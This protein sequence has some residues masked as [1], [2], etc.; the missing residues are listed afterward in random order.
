[1]PRAIG[2]GLL[3]VVLATGCVAGGDT[4]KAKTDGKISEKLLTI[5][6]SGDPLAAAESRGVQTAHDGVLV[7]VQTE[8]LR[9]EDRSRFELDGVRVHHF[10]A[11]YERVSASVRD[12]D[13]LQALAR[14]EPVRRLAPE[15]GRASDDGGTSGGY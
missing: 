7:D 4:G 11:K 6:D 13:A 2:I 3:A 1:M 15:Y 14:I 10:S 8:D 12:A 5:F 9:P